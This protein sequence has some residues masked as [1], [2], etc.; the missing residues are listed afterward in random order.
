MPARFLHRS[1]KMW[2]AERASPFFKGDARRLSKN[3]WEVSEG[4]QAL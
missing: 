3:L 4:P 2:G 1:C